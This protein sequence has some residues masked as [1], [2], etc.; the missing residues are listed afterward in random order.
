M[1]RDVLTEQKTN[2]KFFVKLGKNGQ[3]ILQILEMVYGE[4]AMKC[5][6]VGRPST[7]R[8]EENI[9]RVHDLV[10]TDCQITIRIIAEKLGSNSS[11]QTILEEDSAWI[12]NNA[13]RV[14]YAQVFD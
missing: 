4:S 12:Q 9:Q 7:S 6:T 3:K 11:I 10:K 8:V 14:R 1:E 2:I 5:R 13:H